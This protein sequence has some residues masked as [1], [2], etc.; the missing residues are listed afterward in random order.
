MGNEERWRNQHP[1]FVVEGQSSNVLIIMGSGSLNKYLNWTDRTLPP[2]AQKRTSSRCR[3]LKL[4]STDLK[5]HILGDAATSGLENCA[6][7]SIAGI[8][9]QRAYRSEAS[10]G[11]KPLDLFSF[12]AK[13]CG[14]KHLELLSPSWFPPIGIILHYTL[15]IKIVKLGQLAK[16]IS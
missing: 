16:T 6:G 4:I 14:Y 12:S 15:V 3:S 2:L 8:W 9:I 10:A 1:V 11:W 13:V 7:I 5:E